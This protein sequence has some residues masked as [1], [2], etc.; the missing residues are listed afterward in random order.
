[1]YPFKRYGGQRVAKGKATGWDRVRKAEIGNKDFEL[2]FFEEVYTSQ[3][4]MV[5]VYR[6]KTPDEISISL[7]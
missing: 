6:L 7:Y 4:W 2:D 3:R 5:R 1:L